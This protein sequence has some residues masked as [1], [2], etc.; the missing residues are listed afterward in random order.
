LGNPS[1]GACSAKFVFDCEVARH[2]ETLQSVKAMV[3][4]PIKTAALGFARTAIKPSQ[5]FLGYF[6]MGQ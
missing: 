1:G 3:A 2:G 5:A 6:N 4:M